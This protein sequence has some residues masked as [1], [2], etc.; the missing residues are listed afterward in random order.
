M[1][2]LAEADIEED[3]Y[4]TIEI[5]MKAD[6]TNF[7]VVM[8]DIFRALPMYP[9]IVSN[10]LDYDIYKE[11]IV[12]SRSPTESRYVDVLTR[13]KNCGYQRHLTY[14]VRKRYR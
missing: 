7:K 14:L 3:S 1:M 2:L 8:K 4:S 9:F 10:P 11:Q 6:Q 12:D 5:S 13:N